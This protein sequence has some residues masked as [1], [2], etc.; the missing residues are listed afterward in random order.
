MT[1]AQSLKIK[2]LMKYVTNKVLK[3]LFSKQFYPQGNALVENV[4]NFLKR[5]FTKFL[6]SSELEWDELTPFACYCYIIFPSSNGNE[7]PFFLMFGQDQ[8]KRFLTRPNN[9]NRFYG[10]NEDK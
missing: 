4:H 5:T 10:T 8:A 6:D 1:V 9:S 2:Y 3:G 7:S